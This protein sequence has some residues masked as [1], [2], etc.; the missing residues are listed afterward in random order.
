MVF[1]CYAFASLC[2]LKILTPL[3]MQI[4]IIVIWFSKSQTQRSILDSV[5]LEAFNVSQSLVKCRFVST[6]SKSIRVSPAAPQ[7]CIFVLILC[8]SSLLTL[9]QPSWHSLIPTKPFMN[10]SPCVPSAL[11]VLPV[12]NSCFRCQFNMS[13]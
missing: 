12:A 10:F 6:A 4:Y 7:L 13:F 2:K 8:F 1:L 9:L 5:C 11:N 3:V